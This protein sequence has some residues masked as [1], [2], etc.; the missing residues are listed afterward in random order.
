MKKIIVILFLLFIYSDVYALDD[1]RVNGESLSPL[2]EKEVFVYNYF[3]DSDSIVI[4]VVKD[5][6]EVVSGYGK[7]DVVDGENVFV[8]KVENEENILEYKISV[9]RDYRRYEQVDSSLL[10]SLCVKDYDIGFSSEVFSY[11]VFIDD[12]DYLDISY[13]TYSEN[14]SVKISG[15]GGFNDS[16]NLIEIEVFGNNS[17]NKYVIHARKSVEVF[18]SDKV[19]VRHEFSDFDKKVSATG[20]ICV[21]CFIIFILFYLLFLKK[22]KAC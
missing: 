12:E 20:V 2:F 9:F 18:K 5:E 11:D 6:G 13:E 16:D 3:T 17:S 8:I 21:F 22:K 19:S 14:A 4:S 15:N 10:E 1:I 7:F